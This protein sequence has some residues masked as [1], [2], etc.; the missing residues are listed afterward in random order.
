MFFNNFIYLFYYED[1]HY[2]HP[3]FGKDNLSY[4]THV[5]KNY[6]SSV[7]YDQSGAPV[8]VQCTHSNGMQGIG[9]III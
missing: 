7:I 1:E 6:P 5:L 3:I 4:I 9:I 2:S 8:A